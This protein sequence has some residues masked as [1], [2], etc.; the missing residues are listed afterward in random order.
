MNPVRCDA[1]IVAARVDGQDRMSPN[2][3]TVMVHYNTYRVFPL[4]GAS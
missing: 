2:L 3:I 1:V 4:S